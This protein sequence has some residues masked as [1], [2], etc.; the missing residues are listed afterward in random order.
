MLRL[1]AALTISFGLTVP[2]FA[3]GP[4]NVIVNQGNFN[5]NKIVNI[6]P[7]VVC[8]PGSPGYPG[9]PMPGPSN[10]IFNYGSGNVN[11][12]K[13]IGFGGAGAQNTIVN[14][15]NGNFNKIVNR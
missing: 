1:L 12:V 6:T 15:G 3:Q 13:N 4:S 14:Q 5:V 10:T 8:Y 11:V 2:A 7:P 9:Y